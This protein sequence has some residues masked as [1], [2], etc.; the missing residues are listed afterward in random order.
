MPRKLE[1]NSL[2][3]TNLCGPPQIML[4]GLWSIALKACVFPNLARTSETKL[5]RVVETLTHYSLDFESG[6]LQLVYR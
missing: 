5:E 2:N 1:H 4:L 6:L 3:T